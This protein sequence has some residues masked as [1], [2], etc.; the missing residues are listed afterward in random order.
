MACWGSCVYDLVGAVVYLGPACNNNQNST[1]AAD[2]QEAL[3]LS[4]AVASMP[5][6]RAL[7][8]LAHLEDGRRFQTVD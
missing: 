2:L 8:L 7:A 1:G 4:A 5:N 3:L 6:T